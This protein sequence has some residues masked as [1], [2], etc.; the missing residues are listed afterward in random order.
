MIAKYK[1]EKPQLND[2]KQY[3][4]W[5]YTAK[6]KIQGIDKV[7]DLNVFAGSEQDWA[8]FLHNNQVK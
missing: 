7:V 6:G 1:T 2:N 8:D 4:I 5:Q 3:I